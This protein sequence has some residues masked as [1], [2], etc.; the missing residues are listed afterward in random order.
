MFWILNQV[1]PGKWLHEINS[2]VDYS[3]EECRL[4]FRIVQLLFINVTVWRH[5]W[6]SA[7]AAKT[8]LNFL[9]R[10]RKMR[11]SAPIA[12]SLSSIVRVHSSG[13]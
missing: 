8:W 1:W 10:L 9:I 2:L 7:M 13:G 6:E 3:G 4:Q 12:S 5:K 11:I